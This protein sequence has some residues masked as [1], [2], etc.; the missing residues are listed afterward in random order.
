MMNAPISFDFEES[1]KSSLSFV[2]EERFENA[3]HTHI[4][5][6]HRTMKMHV[7]L[8]DMDVL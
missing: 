2:G 7:T 6:R 3:T 4:S 8:F 5:H 1:S